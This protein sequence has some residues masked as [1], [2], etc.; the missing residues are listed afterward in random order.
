MSL[1]NFFHNFETR[2]SKC[3]YETM[4]SPH[5]TFFARLRKC[6]CNVL[7]LA[8]RRHCEFCIVVTTL[9]Q[10][11]HYNINDM[12]SRAEGALIHH[13]DFDV[14]VLTL[15]RCCEFDVNIL[16]LQQRFQYNIHITPWIKL[17]TKRWGNDE[18]TL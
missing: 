18:A 1:R 14:I 13:C 11:C 17:T 16:T 9:Y 15:W 3:Y 4:N 12:S 2:L 8:S 10:R 5:F 7:V 6:W